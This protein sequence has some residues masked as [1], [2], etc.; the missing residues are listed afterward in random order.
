M[1]VHPNYTIDYDPASQT[2]I[3]CFTAAWDA[4]TNIDAFKQAIAHHDPSKTNILWDFRRASFSRFNLEEIKK[5]RDFRAAYSAQRSGT[6][7]CALV[8]EV[9]KKSLMELYHEV[10]IGVGPLTMVFLT[11]REARDYLGL[12]PSVSLTPDG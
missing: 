11:E 6:K 10:N 4:Q 9:V 7:S 8:D 12:S 3:V 5:L 2:V 1:L